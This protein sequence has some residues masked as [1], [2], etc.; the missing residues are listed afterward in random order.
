MIHLKKIVIKLKSIEYTGDSIG[1]DIEAEVRILDQI[2]KF[3]KKFKPGSIYKINEK[4]AEFP[5]DR[6]TFEA[7]LGLEIIETDPI[8][9]DVGNLTRQIRINTNLEEPQKFS[10][11]VAV[12]E[13]RF[14]TTKAKA[15]F[16]FSLTAEVYPTEQYVPEMKSG[17]LV[18][19]IKG[20]K[21]PQGIP[22]YLR[23][24]VH[25][26]DKNFDYFTILEG[27]YK[28][29]TGR[30]S[31]KPNGSSYFSIGI[32]DRNKDVQAYYSIS[33]KEFYLNGKS[34]KVI[35][36]PGKPWEKRLYDIEIP[37]APHGGGLNYPESAKATVWVRIGHT[38]DR[39]LHTGQH[40]L[41]CM[42]II[43][44]NRWNEIFETL[45]QA[46]KSDNQSV[47]TLEVID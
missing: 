34:Y 18:V 13:L 42:T 20:L 28:N 37:D 17:W 47:G 31:K 43:E 16:K 40:T 12:K 1:D 10:Y 3:K 45:I 23:V 5:S 27:A 33:K 46:R 25:K 2:F 15:I 44:T 7:M 35:E 21:E 19:N 14:K 41:G 29:K 11:E 8:F 39:Y 32:L 9:N 6:N 38:G 22:A 4:I 30:V 36:Y 24:Q 26:S